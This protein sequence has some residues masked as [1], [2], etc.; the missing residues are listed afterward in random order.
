MAIY[1]TYELTVVEF[2]IYSNL[3]AVYQI[4]FLF[5]VQWCWR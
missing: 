3:G 2:I 1:T 4:Q 5:S